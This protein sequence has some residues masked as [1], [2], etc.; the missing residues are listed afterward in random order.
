MAAVFQVARYAPV[1]TH[2]LRRVA[3]A[4]ANSFGDFLMARLVIPSGPG[5]L[6]ILSL[7]I[8]SKM[9]SVVKGVVQPAVRGS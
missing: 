1:S 7:L 2:R 5:A 9:W 4:V 6:P 8:D 3:K